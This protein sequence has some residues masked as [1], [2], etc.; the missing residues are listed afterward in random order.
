M[1]ARFAMNPFG[2]VQHS[3]RLFALAACLAACEPR[4]PA[5]PQ[6]DA[7]ELQLAASGRWRASNAQ[8]RDLVGNL[9]IDSV[10]AAR[11][12]ITLAFAN[13][14]TVWAA[15]ALLPRDDASVRELVDDM[16]DVLGAPPATFP[17][18]Y[19]VTDERV[20]T[21]A[22][23]GGLCGGLRTR[24]VAVAT[25]DDAAGVPQLRLASFHTGLG[26][27]PPQRPESGRLKPCFAFDYEAAGPY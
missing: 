11:G 9:S 2:Q 20:A 22:P 25:F 26:A 8:A 24:L 19:A 10:D 14:V 21:S 27:P 17:T 5:T 1:T 7:A 23:A 3:A 18:L 4:D 12:A 13:G 16:R 15:P 6:P